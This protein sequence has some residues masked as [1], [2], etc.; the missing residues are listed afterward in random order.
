MSFLTAISGK[1]IKFTSK[2]FKAVMI[3][4]IIIVFI[5][6]YFGFLNPKIKNIREYS[7]YD[8]QEN[9]KR[10]AER[11][12][13]LEGLKSV[14]EQYQQWRKEELEKVDKALP[15]G[16][17]YPGIFSQMEKLVADAGYL[18]TNISISQVAEP[19]KKTNQ[20]PSTQLPSNV[21]MLNVQINVAAPADYGYDNF[22][23]LLDTMENNI[24]L[25]DVT[26]LNFDPNNSSFRLNLRTYYLA[27]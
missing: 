26:S 18:V 16:Q 15:T 12:N 11:Q 10:L 14:E 23:T 1:L 9:D 2:Y 3:V 8:Y 7:I 13:Y 17:D 19:S 20:K 25:I 5:I 27:S 4:I 6:C 21:N 22:K 24:R